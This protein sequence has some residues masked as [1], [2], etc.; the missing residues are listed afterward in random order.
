MDYL[1]CV[2]G[3]PVAQGG[4]RGRTEATGRG[5]FFGIREACDVAEDMKALGLGTGLEGKT[6]VIQGLGNVGYHTARFLEDGS[7]FPQ[8]DAEDSVRIPFAQAGQHGFRIRA[9]RL[10]ASFIFLSRTSSSCS[11]R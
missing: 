2:T 7:P 4:I 10:M 9:A 3:K 8:F 11:Y 5:V 1:A 6:V